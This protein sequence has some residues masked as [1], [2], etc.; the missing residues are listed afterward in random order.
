M[1]LPCVLPSCTGVWQLDQISLGQAPSLPKMQGNDRWV[2]ESMDQQ[3]TDE[4]TLP[5]PEYLL[6]VSWSGR[7]A[8]GSCLSPW[9]PF[10]A[11][12]LTEQQP[13]LKM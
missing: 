2:T 3:H 12:W 9:K 6:T 1:E 4:L 10:E 7:A 11:L 8:V 13:N 5:V